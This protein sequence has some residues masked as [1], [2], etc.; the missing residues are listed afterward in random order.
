VTKQLGLFPPAPYPSSSAVFSTDGL[1]RFELRRVW[2]PGQLVAWIMLNPSTATADAD[3]ATIRKITKYS[4]KWGF[5]GLIVGNLYAWR[6]RD[7]KQLLKVDAPIGFENDQHLK[8]IADEASLIVCAWGI[9][10][11][12]ARA[13]WVIGLLR[14]TGKPLHCIGRNED[15]SPCHPLFKPGHLKPMPLEVA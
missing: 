8:R 2:G 15:S 12:A 4:K 13:T 10:A 1:Y 6:S 3:D 11:E 14:L 7:P 5:G 9:N